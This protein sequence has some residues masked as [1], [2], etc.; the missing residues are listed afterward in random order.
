LFGRQDKF[1]TYTDFQKSLG[2]NK[3]KM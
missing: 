1:N 3:W 2:R